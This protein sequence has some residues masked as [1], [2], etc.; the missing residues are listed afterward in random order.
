M[1]HLIVIPLLDLSCG[2]ILWCYLPMAN[3]LSFA[4]P[5]ERTKEKATFGQTAPQ[6]K[7][8]STLLSFGYPQLHGAV[9]RPQGCYY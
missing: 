4:S 7:S 5:K 3:V 9:L 2:H 6:A 1:H 8:S